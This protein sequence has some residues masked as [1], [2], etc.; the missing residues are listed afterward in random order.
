MQLINIPEFDVNSDK[1][2]HQHLKR[3]GKYSKSH[4]SPTLE[5]VNVLA[6]TNSVTTQHIQEK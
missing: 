3:G 1:K 5:R 6:Y 2:I 4:S